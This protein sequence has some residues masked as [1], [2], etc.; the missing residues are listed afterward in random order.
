M[1][2]NYKE[3]HDAIK[4]LLTNYG[5][6]GVNAIANKLG[7][8]VSSIQYYLKTQQ[9]Y[10]VQNNKR[11]WQLPDELEDLWEDEKDQ[12]MLKEWLKDPDK[13]LTQVLK[14]IQN[15]KD[16]ISIMQRQVAFL[17]HNFKIRLTD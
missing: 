17:E 7:I 16:Q 10:F 6:M 1:A 5:P 13:H 14:T 9:S 15:A 4:E 11:K 3:Y 2:S 12:E 8:P